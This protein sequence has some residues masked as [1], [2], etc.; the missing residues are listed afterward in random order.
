MTDDTKPDRSQSG[1]DDEVDAADAATSAAPEAS[2]A[3]DKPSA[4]EKTIP[5][6]ASAEIPSS[7]PLASAGARFGGRYEIH[8]ILG[9]GGMG[10]VYRA[11]DLELDEEIAIKVLQRQLTQR[12]SDVRRFKR[13]IKTARRISHRNVIRIHDFGFAD[14][15]AF[16]SMEYLPGGTLA[17][18]MEER[19]LDP[20]IALDIA[21]QIAAGLTA[22]HAEGVVH[23]DI[24]PHNVLFDAKGV[25]KLVDFGIARFSEATSHTAGIT[26]TPHYMSPEQAD[27][28]EVTER[29]D[30]YSLGV[31]MFEMFTGQ[32]PFQSTSLAKLA[33]QHV[34]E[35]PPLPRSIEPAISPELESLI[36][37][38]LAK[39]PDERF[40][41]GRKVHEALQ[42]LERGEKKIYA[43]PT[44]PGARPAARQQR[45][46]MGW[47]LV[48]F[49]VVVVFGGVLFTAWR[50]F[51]DLRLSQFSTPAPDGFVSTPRGMRSPPPDALD[52]SPTVTATPTAT[53][54]A[55][56]AVAT[57]TATP[58]ARRTPRYRRRT[59]R[60][61]T[62]T[63]SA[64]A[65]ATPSP[66]PAPVQ[67]VNIPGRV[68]FLFVPW[69]DIEIARLTDGKRTVIIRE[70][71]QK[72]YT[73]SIPPG[74]Y[75]MRMVSAPTW[76]PAVRTFE[77]RPGQLT[78]LRF[79]FN[80]QGRPR[81]H[82]GD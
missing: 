7:D 82:S 24:K 18:A 42:A 32:R 57:P 46:G 72:K 56:V 74:K 81:A 8:E 1:T 6:P 16:I 66:T 55:S 19:R 77:V 14:R 65:T 58:R 4:S 22:A 12:E 25:V 41:N 71:E 48:L 40:A 80:T 50:F 33:M 38:C 21:V 37:K 79:D 20:D 45:I 73:T 63:P 68:E 36:L 34:A 11:H 10:L 31:L 67:A 61:A 44:P 75:A 28:R 35:M 3:G 9:E 54:V 2:L 13:E 29:S 17:D 43:A 53:P 70:A 49:S 52:V 39:D 30:V 62:P 59:P 26:G 5:P 23:R 47:L 64:V 60:P 27:G 15:D 78:K 76:E 51:P 69:A